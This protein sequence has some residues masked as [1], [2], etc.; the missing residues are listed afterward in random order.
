M[1][2][3]PSDYWQTALDRMDAALATAARALDRAED[4]WERAF[5]PS[6]GEGEPPPALARV[7]ARLEAWEAQ[8]EAARAAATAA[9]SEFAERAETVDRWRALFARW[10]QLLQREQHTPPRS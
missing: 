7:D 9:E 6:A 1:T 8:L 5:A 2:P 4:R 10:E 3:L